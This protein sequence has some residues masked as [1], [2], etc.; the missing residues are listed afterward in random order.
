[1]MT[2]H[3]CGRVTR[4]VFSRATRLASACFTCVTADTQVL[5]KPRTFGLEVAYNW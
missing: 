3:S 2:N 5:A 1:M 4:L